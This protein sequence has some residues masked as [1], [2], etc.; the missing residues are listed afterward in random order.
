M[1]GASV[2]GSVIDGAQAALSAGC[3]MVLICNAPDKADQLLHGLKVNADN[4]LAQSAAR[5]AALVPQAA[6]PDWD[7]LQNDARYKAARKLAQ[8][9]VAK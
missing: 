6:A 2:A 1:E 9:L 4:K 5:V 3:D 7:S 8:S